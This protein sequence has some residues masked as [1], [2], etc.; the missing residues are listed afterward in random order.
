MPE[1]S[2]AP[3]DRRDARGAPARDV[4]RDW[5]WRLRRRDRSDLGRWPF[6]AGICATLATA[7]GVAA[8]LQ[9]DAFDPPQWRVIG[10]V[11]LAVLPWIIDLLLVEVPPWV[12]APAVIVPVAILHDA[13][14]FDPLQLLLAVLALD[15]GLWLG[16][17]RSAPVVL[18]SAAVVLGQSA[19][20]SVDGLRSFTRPLGGIAV[21]WLVGLALHSQVVRIARL[22]SRQ[23][24]AVD[25]AVTAERQHM[26]RGVYEH[27]V[28]L[29]A[30]L[31]EL[32][33]SRAALERGEIEEA[34]E[35]AAAAERLGR[36]TIDGLHQQLG[37]MTTGERDA[38]EPDDGLETS[39][40][41]S[42]A[43]DPSAAPEPETT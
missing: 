35:G 32:S 39:D 4:V 40:G 14:Q 15:M 17:A 25:R 2:L 31:V 18:V 12:F 24:E 38:G 26:A 34:R 20:A 37:T 16:P 29:E 13:T 43:V 10:L 21:A 36:E 6:R 33:A 9:R 11:A 19:A 3:T 41:R 1:R 42:G 7:A 28:R 30:M 8:L 5:G 27:A 23:R 22:R